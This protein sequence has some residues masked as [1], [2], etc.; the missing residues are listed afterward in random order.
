M[1]PLRPFQAG[2][3]GSGSGSGSGVSRWGMGSHGGVRAGSASGAIISGPG[4]ISGSSG[5]ERALRRSP[6]LRC[7]TAR[8]RAQAMAARRR[9]EAEAREAA[10]IAESEILGRRRTS[11]GASKGGLMG[12]VRTGSGNKSP[13]NNRRRLT[14]IPVCVASVQ[15][16]QHSGTQGMASGS[17]SSDAPVTSPLEHVKQ[18]SPAQNSGDDGDNEADNEDEDEERAADLPASSHFLGTGVGIGMGRG[19]VSPPRNI[20][21]VGNAAADN[22]GQDYQG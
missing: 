22:S 2:G 14:P 10:R 9:A 12:H 15:V 6:R 13:T 5:G 7:R 1:N 11:K 4:R 19:I 17:R 20:R 21:G 8:S 16:P 3:F 18:T